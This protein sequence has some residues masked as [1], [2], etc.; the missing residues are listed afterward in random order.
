MAT[1]NKTIGIIVGAC[2]LVGGI[3]A[4]IFIFSG[5]DGKKEDKVEIK[6]QVKR[7]N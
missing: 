4:L 6:D 1:N 2:L 3:I 5:G 7:E